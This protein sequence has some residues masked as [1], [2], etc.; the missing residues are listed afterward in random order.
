MKIIQ[1]IILGILQGVTEFIPISSSAHLIV[2]P[3]GWAGPT[4]TPGVRHRAPLGHAAR[5]LGSSTTGCDCYTPG[6]S[7]MTM[8]G[9]Q[10]RR[11]SRRT[12]AR[13]VVDHRLHSRRGHRLCSKASSNGSS[14]NPI[15]SPDE[16]DDHRVHPAPGGMLLA[17]RSN[18]A[19]A[20]SAE[21]RAHH[22]FRPGV[23]DLSG[24]V[25]SGATITAGLALGCRAACRGAFLLLLSAP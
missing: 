10:D 6:V 24:R 14:T 8:R 17:G 11:R 19:W 20:P 12:A 21:G 7:S 4:S 9:A 2:V 1:A 16:P 23:G 5:R 13:L 15:A 25:A 3:W 18:A 22:W